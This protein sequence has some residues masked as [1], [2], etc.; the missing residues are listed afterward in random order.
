MQC[1]RNPD[2]L[3]REPEPKLQAIERI[4]D[5]VQEFPVAN[6]HDVI[7]LFDSRWIAHE[8]PELGDFPL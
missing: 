7:N 5:V 1:G 4:L 6:L 8:F 2:L 3:F